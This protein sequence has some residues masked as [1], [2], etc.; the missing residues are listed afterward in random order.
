MSAQAQMEILARVQW[1]P[2]GNVCYTEGGHTNHISAAAC[3]LRTGLNMK[4]WLCISP[5]QDG[6][7]GSAHRDVPPM[8]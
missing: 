1:T 5:I 8:C 4:G 3:G 6:N 7:T 2:L